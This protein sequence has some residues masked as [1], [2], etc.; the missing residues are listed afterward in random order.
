MSVQSLALPPDTKLWGVVPKAVKPVS[1][2]KEREEQRIML[3]AETRAKSYPSAA[4]AD[5]SKVSVSVGKDQGWA[6]QEAATPDRLSS[7]KHDGKE[8]AALSDPIS[9]TFSQ[10]QV[11]PESP[12]KVLRRNN[13]SPVVEEMLKV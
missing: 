13:Q 8:T 10:P 4:H 3:G 5:K 11:S 1:Q 12:S 2:E 6:R 7:D 9:E